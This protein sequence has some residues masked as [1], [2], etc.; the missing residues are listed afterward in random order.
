MR[1]LV[2]SLALF[3]L[4]LSLLAA[5][6][7]AGG[8]LEAH[9]PFGPSGCGADA[10][11]TVIIPQADYDAMGK[12]PLRQAPIGQEAPLASPYPLFQWPLGRDINDGYALVNYF[13]EDATTLIK[14][15]MGGS[16]SYNGH[17]GTDLTLFNF[18]AMDRGEPILAAA[19]GTVLA[20]ADGN[21]DRNYQAPFGPV[22]YILL[23][24]LDGTRTYYYHL[25]KYS[26]TVS[27]GETVETGQV[28]AMVGSSG[29][30]S[31]AHLHFE[32]GQVSGGWHARDPWNGPN[33]LQPSLWASQKPYVGND[34]FH[35]YDA[36]MSTRTAVGGDENNVPTSYYKERFSQPDTMGAGEPVAIFWIQYEVMTGD[37]YRLEILRPNGSL[38]SSVDRSFTFTCAYC[39]DYWYW[40]WSGNVFPWDYGTWTMRILVGGSPVSTVPFDVG[41]TTSYAP[42]FFPLAG[43]SYRIMGGTIYDDLSVSSLGGPVTYSLLNEPSSVTLAGNTVTMAWPSTQEL[44]SC[45]FQAIA[46]DA[47]A[48]QDTMRYHLVD[49]SKPV[50]IPA[51]VPPLAGGSIEPLRIVSFPNPSR[52][53]ATIGYTLERTESGRIGIYDTGGRLVRTLLNGTIEARGDGSIIE[54]DG[55]SSAGEPAP[56]GTYICRLDAG[57]R[58]VAG[59]LVLI[60]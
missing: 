56:A 52:G 32:P 5:P 50:V 13:D 53:K 21:T 23:D 42:R 18:R 45:Y 58:Q 15:Y 11:N 22:N 39:W 41:P 38:Y 30:S 35:V 9:G 44:R 48:R 20:T 4:P 33:N 34:H 31:D 57:G 10:A 14:D 3:V 46:T 55:R 47:Y 2:V 60:R 28:I 8:R 54:W 24:N 17:L 40:Y 43:R 12:N 7:H 19:P 49:M 16:R 51:G 59:K 26:V 27:V 36:G 6:A 1:P 29:N 37:A 25:R